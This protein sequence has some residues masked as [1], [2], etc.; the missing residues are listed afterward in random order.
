MFSAA[1]AWRLV[2]RGI[3]CRSVLDD[4]D[5]LSRREESVAEAALAQDRV[6]V[7]ERVADFEILREQREAEGGPMPQLI[8]AAAD[9]F[10]RNREF[11][12]AIVEALVPAACEHRAGRHGGVYWLD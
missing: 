1:L 2:D 6:L 12:A 10:P 4:S 8:Y 5:L 3:E 7:T 9:R 11:L